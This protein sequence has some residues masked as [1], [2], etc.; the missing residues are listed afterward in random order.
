VSEL[1]NECL[2]YEGAPIVVII[3]SLF[4]IIY[5][6]SCKIVVLVGIVV[7]AALLI[8]AQRTKSNLRVLAV[9]QQKAKYRY[10]TVDCVR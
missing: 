5:S 1:V 7:G 10:I 2:C 6:N 9:L 4:N 8:H 3:I